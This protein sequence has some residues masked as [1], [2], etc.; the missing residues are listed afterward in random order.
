MVLLCYI[1]LTVSLIYI[2][3]PIY[4]NLQITSVY[5]VRLIASVICFHAYS[6]LA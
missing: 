6:P 4:Y 5:E 3:I 1:P 2:F